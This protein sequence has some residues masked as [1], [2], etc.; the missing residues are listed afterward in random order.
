MKQIN[1]FLDGLIE[2][3]RLNGER[4]AILDRCQDRNWCAAV[5]VDYTAVDVYTQ[6]KKK[7]EEYERR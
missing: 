5:N 3:I 7:V 6:I 1:P 4:D 2:D